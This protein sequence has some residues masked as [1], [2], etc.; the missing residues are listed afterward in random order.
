MCVCV[1]VCVCHTFNNH[2]NIYLFSFIETR[3]VCLYIP[4]L[5]LCVILCTHEMLL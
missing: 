1:C 5:N 4:S 3:N 2:Y